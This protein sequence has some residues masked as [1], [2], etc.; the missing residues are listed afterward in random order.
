MKEKKIKSL[1]KKMME[2]CKHVT[3][4]VVEGKRFFLSHEQM[5]QS[6]PF[7]SLTHSSS[8]HSQDV[9]YLVFLV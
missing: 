6:P 2:I 9:F 8:L 7:F 1:K 3:I 4:C 5:L